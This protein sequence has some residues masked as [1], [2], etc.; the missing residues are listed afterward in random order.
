MPA[1][2]NR[3]THAPGVRHSARVGDIPLIVLI[4]KCPRVNV[5]KC[6]LL[7]SRT[8]VLILIGVSVFTGIL[9]CLPQFDSGKLRL[10]HPTED[11]NLHNASTESVSAGEVAI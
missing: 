10:G 4:E 2:A 11:A 6:D 5:L 9:R 3:N 8:L 7:A 1:F